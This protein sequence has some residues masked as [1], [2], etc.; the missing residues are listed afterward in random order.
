M[1]PPDSSGSQ[2]RRLV[3]SYVKGGASH[4]VEVDVPRSGDSEADQK[5][6][7]SHFVQTLVDNGQL[8]GPSATHEIVT[9]PDGTAVLK[10]RGFR[11]NLA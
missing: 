2:T 6:E 3:V 1:S 7:A 10:R 5:A 9:G 8:D 4:S 11:Q